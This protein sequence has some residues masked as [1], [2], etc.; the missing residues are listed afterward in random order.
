M[1]FF[2]KSLTVGLGQ[3]LAL[4]I[5]V[6][7][8]SI[9]S[10]G[11]GPEFMGNL[12]LVRTSQTIIV[13]FFALGVGQ[14]SIYF[15]NQKKV[16]IEV[17]VSNTIW[18]FFI[19]G[20]FFI[21]SNLL[22][23]KLARN[24]FGYLRNDEEV[25]LYGFGLLM[26]FNSFLNPIFIAKL[27]SVNILISNNLSKFVT[28]II[29]FVLFL[30]H[31][32]SFELA[33]LS[34]FVGYVI[35]SS[36]ILIKT[37]RYFSLRISINRQLILKI[38]PFGIKLS[39]ANIVFLMT[40]N[41]L[42][43]VVR[44]FDLESFTELGLFTRA[45]FLSNLIIIIPNALVPLFYSRWASLEGSKRLDEFNFILQLSVLLS[46]IISLLIFQFSDVVVLILFGSEYLSAVIYI[47]LVA[48]VFIFSTITHVSINLF[49]SSGN[50][51]K[52]LSIMIFNF[53]LNL[54]VGL[55]SISFFGVIGA[56]YTLMISNLLVA[57]FSL[58]LVSHTY[59]IKLIYLFNL[60]LLVTK[61][62]TIINERKD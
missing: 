47:K 1:S 40:N 52:P 46:G 53:I 57:L 18:I 43:F 55:I 61:I 41:V 50:P 59:K 7:T 8:S 44:I 37:R 24:Y 62:K 34:I 45:V 36:F 33:L 51:S 28:L 35:N 23:F 60:Q 48:P 31:E 26:L 2:K 15:I 21:F 22:I 19:S 4:V 6:L 39:L 25:Y 5:G 27:E 14:A 56:A 12:E 3:V 58:A 17:I 29:L 30:F 49:N 54:S 42:I 16:P 32:V 10:R 13:A 11:L 38:I 9:L 20:L